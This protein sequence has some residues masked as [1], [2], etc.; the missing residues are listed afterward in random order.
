MKQE[1]LPHMS[2]LEK[3]LTQELSE[4]E[5]RIKELMDE[6]SALKRQIGKASAKRK[7]LEFTTRKNSLNRV[8]AE[9]SV[10]EVLRES[11]RPAATATLYKQARITNP[12]LKENTFRT[13]LHRMKKKGSIQTARRA[14][15]WKLPAP[16]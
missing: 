16:S 12:Y 1:N 6:A 8:L 10:L 11:G 14:G 13:Y 7:G 5:I 9:N 15:E 2:P 4:V 3:A